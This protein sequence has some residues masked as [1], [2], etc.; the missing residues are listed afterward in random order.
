M[1]DRELVKL[2]KK[3]E[4]QNSTVELAVLSLSP[5]IC[6]LIAEGSSLSGIVTLLTNGAFLSIFST[7]NVSKKTRRMY[8][9][10]ISTL[11]HLSDTIVFLFLGIGIIA[12]DHPWKKMGFS[13]IFLALINLNI[14]R[15]LNIGITTF[16]IN[17]SRGKLSKISGK[18][19]FVMWI[20]GLR[21]AMAYALALDTSK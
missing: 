11:A 19:Q 7:P 3:E 15:G 16:L 1:S 21:G 2:I 20:A 14:A 5:V 17:C 18:Q 12:F 4:A 10:T 13:T 9:G 8:R 6:Y